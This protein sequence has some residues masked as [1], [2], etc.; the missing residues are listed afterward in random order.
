MTFPLKL[1][2]H[3]PRTGTFSYI[4]I[5]PLLHLRKLTLSRYTHPT[6]MHIQIS[7]NVLYKLL[8]NILFSFVFIFLF[9]DPISFHLWYLFKSPPI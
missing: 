5:I 3:L 1:S 9:Q 2:M 7:P 8:K 4:I 6:A